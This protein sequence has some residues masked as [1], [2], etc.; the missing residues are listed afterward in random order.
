MKTIDYYNKNAEKYFESTVNANM[1]KAYDFFQKYVPSGRILDFGC[2]SG[3]DSLYFKNQGYEVIAIDGSEEL[4]KLAREYTGLDVRCM[5][6]FDLRDIGYYDGIWASASLLHVDKKLL[7]NVLKKMRDALKK[8]GYMY[9][10][11]KNGEGEEITEEGRYYNYLTRENF[12]N[13][14]NRAGLEEV[15]FYSDKSVSNPNEMRYWNSF[16]LKRK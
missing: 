8:S 3:R 1:Q 6:F 11:M 13:V 5:N 16:I 9:V 12:L 14:A 15:D 2:G 7:I 10:A 4:C